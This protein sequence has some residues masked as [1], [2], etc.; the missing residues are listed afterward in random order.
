VNSLK[1]E[2]KNRV[3]DIFEKFLN[4]HYFQCRLLD[5][6]GDFLDLDYHSRK[7]YITGVYTNCV[8]PYDFYDI[9]QDFSDIKDYKFDFILS[10]QMNDP[11]SL[12]QM[13]D[14]L[15]PF[16]QLIIS[17]P[18]LIPSLEKIDIVS[19]DDDLTLIERKEY[20]PKRIMI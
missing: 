16:G 9:H 20:A 10:L 4:S 8:Y 1:E 11:K 5:V 17:T 7:I 19:Q 12:K 13:I 15:N 2:L 14:M 18:E 3:R 6:K